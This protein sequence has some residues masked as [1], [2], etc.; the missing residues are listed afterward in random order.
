MES[1]MEA[2]ANVLLYAIP[3]LYSFVVIEAVYS[4]RKGTKAFESL[5]TISSISSGLA[6]TIKSVLGLTLFII[7]YEKLEGYIAVFEI[8]SSWLLYL[9]AFLS[10]DFAAYWSHR[11][12]HE[13]NFFWNK[14]VSHHGSEE[15]NL[16]VAFRQPVSEF[17]SLFF[18]FMFPAA[19]LGVPPEVVALLTPLHFLLQFWIHTP[20]IGKLGILEYII[21]TPSQ[22][23]VHHALNEIYLDKN[24]SGVFCIWDRLFGTFQEELEDEPPVYGST[25]P[26]HTWNPFKQNFA[27]LSLLIRDAWY[28]EHWKDKLRVWVM[29][30]GWRPEDVKTRFPVSSVNERTFTK[31]R[32]A[33]SP[34]LHAWSWI[35]C[36]IANVMLIHLLASFNEIGF[37]TLF[38]YGGF[39]LLSVYAFTSL[40]DRD[41]NALWIEFMR[42]VS[43]LIIIYATGDWFATG[44]VR[45][46]V[47]AYL[48]F[49]V[50]VSWSLVKKGL[51]QPIPD[52]FQTQ[53]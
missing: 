1:S 5:D 16:A 22:H 28:T 8:R 53:C 15:Y 37:P 3:V 52:N 46:I 32:P 13:I 12:S 4:W 51:S 7:G 48:I 45:W 18:L 43:G 36:L 39:L 25:R 20:H 26:L 42:A 14:H 23:R 21:V 29:P 35:Q 11:L 38:I 34:A 10:L 44:N 27:H 30:T 50:L 6:N 40:M 17:V 41:K 9:I 31:Y 49:S 47:A 19:L 24:L 33:V 2:Y